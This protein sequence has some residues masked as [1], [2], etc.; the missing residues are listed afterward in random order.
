L[1]KFSGRLPSS[2]ATAF[3]TAI[4]DIS[5]RVSTDALAM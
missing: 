1:S 2:A 3:R 5:R 4:I